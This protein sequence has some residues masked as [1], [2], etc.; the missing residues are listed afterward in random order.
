MVQEI[1]LKKKL[2]VAGKEVETVTLDFEKITG[3]VLL[4]AEKA[5]R[6]TGDVTPVLQLSMHFQALI[7]AQLIGVPVEDVKELNCGD[8]M[9]I[10]NAVRDFLLS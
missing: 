4:S 7:A 3:D 6:A 2:S 5:L 9:K 1:T 10:V 8:F